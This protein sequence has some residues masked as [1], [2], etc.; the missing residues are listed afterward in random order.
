M[1]G[2]DFIMKK[3]IIFII[4]VMLVGSMNISAFA[5]SIP[6]TYGSTGAKADSTL[7]LGDMLAYAIQDEY[8]AK[9][10]YETIIE[11]YGNIRPFSNIIKAEERHIDLLTPLFNEYDI[12]IP[13]DKASSYVS[14]PSTLLDSMK[15]GVSAELSNIEMYDRF[16]GQELPDDV[17]TVFESLRKASVSHLKAFERG[18]NREEG[19]NTNTNYGRANRGRR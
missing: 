10:E 2:V 7:T 6:E 13:E 15:A 19:N 17:R 16:L 1:N 18:V 9:A 14:A 3:A 8:V 4:M 5:G 11:K 12:K